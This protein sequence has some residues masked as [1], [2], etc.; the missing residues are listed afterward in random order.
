MADHPRP[1]ESEIVEAQRD[2]C[3]LPDPEQLELIRDQVPGRDAA[4]AVAVV[5]RRGRGRPTGARNKRNT[6]F[7]D[8]ILGLGP[9]PALAL[10]RAYSTP[11]EALAATLGCSRLEAY[12]LQ[13]RAAAE[14]L[15]YIEGKMPVQLDIR[16]AHDVVLIMGG[17]PGVG[18]DQLEAI[19]REV[20]G[21][22]EDE[23]DWG[24]ATFEELPEA[25]RNGEPLRDSPAASGD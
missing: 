22:G 11:V 7:R 17:A 1:L 23:I 4:T 19:A 13:V 12:Q 2:L 20:G 25:V 9:H 10:Q 21:A 24:S 8:Q 5:E 6:K 3:A 15:P 18:G 16:Q 14:L